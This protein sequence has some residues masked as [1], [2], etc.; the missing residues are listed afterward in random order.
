[1]NMGKDSNLS[2][3]GRFGLAPLFL[4]GFLFSWACFSALTGRM[5]INYGFWLGATMSGAITVS[6]A[7]ILF[8]AWLLDVLDHRK[9]FRTTSGTN[10]DERFSTPT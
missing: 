8:Y 6:G 10:E 4:G 3:I 5:P 2:I 1:M 7:G 9:R